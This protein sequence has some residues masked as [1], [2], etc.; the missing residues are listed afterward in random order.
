MKMILNIYGLS[1][2]L[3]VKIHEDVISYREDL[4]NLN[5]SNSKCAYAE[6]VLRMFERND[7]TLMS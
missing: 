3:H 2:A 5:I 1:V 6:S 4:D 7:Y